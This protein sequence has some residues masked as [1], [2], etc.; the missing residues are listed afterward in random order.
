MEYLKN[1]YIVTLYIILGIVIYA[2]GILFTGGNIGA[3]EIFLGIVMFVVYYIADIFDFDDRRY[4]FKIFL[5]SFGINIALCIFFSFIIGVK[6]S[7]YVFLFQFIYQNIT[8]VLVLDFA[9][10]Q[11]KLVIMGMNYRN[12]MI[13]KVVLD[14]GIY[15]IAGVI[16]RDGIIK[17][18]NNILGRYE[19]V[20]DICR[21]HHID[22]IVVTE[23]GV[24]TQE[25]L[26][27]LIDAKL[28]GARIYSFLE[29]YEKSE[30]KVPLKTLNEQ[31]F[32]FGK[33]FEILHN[34]FYGKVKR[35]ADL[36]FAIVVL[37]PAF[38]VMLIAALIIKIESRGPI[39]FVQDRI[40]KENKR[41]KIIKFRSMVVHNKEEYSK[42]AGEKDNRITR[43]GNFM[44]KTRIDELPQL[45][46]VF[47]GDMSF[48][49]PRP[50]WDELCMGYMEKIP[51]Y[52][53]RHSVQPGLTGW[54]QVNYR[55]GASIEDAI[56]KL[57]YDLYYIKHYSL[58]LDIIIFFK[59][60]K[61]V[62]F[63]R[64]R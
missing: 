23:E 51:F 35:I 60:I 17:D 16:T 48:V 55:Y 46:N 5:V 58:M 30:E 44:R 8:K 54:A 20:A 53:L 14:K 57:Q 11:K 52:S 50:E 2:F 18:G 7:F 34:N 21:E 41:F 10:K 29:F 38:P 28:D 6:E 12:D 40:G 37:I 43:F 33:G 9:F 31:W 15:S 36:I 25:V 62:V 56:E 3:K 47:R 1:K 22:K 4:K 27:R 63:G 39:F 59:T 49:G 61:T 13:K 19:Q 26:A 45:I 32:L 24:L 42:Y 64:G